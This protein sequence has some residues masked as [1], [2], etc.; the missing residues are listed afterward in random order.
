MSDYQ[1]ENDQKYFT[2]KIIKTMNSFV[3]T[4]KLPLIISEQV[5]NINNYP[6]LLN[7][8]CKFIRS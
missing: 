1:I 7:K 3:Y 2:E 8:F 4:P 5:S 6:S